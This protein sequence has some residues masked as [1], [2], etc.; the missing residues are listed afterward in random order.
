MQNA[1]LQ[2]ENNKAYDYAMFLLNIRL[3]T[4]GELRE[5]MK[6]KKYNAGVVEVVMSKLKESRYIDDQRFAEVYLENL[7]KY[8]NWGYYGIKKKLIEKRLPSEIIESVLSA[9]LSEEAEVEIAKKFIK[10]ENSLPL[11]VRRSLGEG[12]RGRVKGGV[13]IREEKSRL[14][15]KLAAKGFRSS[16]VSKLIFLNK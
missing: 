15:R 5:K 3:R 1:K 7:K 9:G 6:G 2:E 4:E 12:G 14:A 16:V 10:K 11:P 8:K 13:M